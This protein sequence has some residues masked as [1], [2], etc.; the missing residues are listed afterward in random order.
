MKPEEYQAYFE[1]FVF[2]ADNLSTIALAMC[3]LDPFAMV[4]HY[5]SV[6]LR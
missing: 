5:N 4:S 1:D 3:G 2:F 6:M